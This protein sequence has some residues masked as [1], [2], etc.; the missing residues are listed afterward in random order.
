MVLMTNKKNYHQILPLILS[1]EFCNEAG[2]PTQDTKLEDPTLN[3]ISKCIRIAMGLKLDTHIKL[4][5]QNKSFVV[6]INAEHNEL[7]NT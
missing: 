2:F 6:T 5:T 1:A 3:Y 4:S 7:M